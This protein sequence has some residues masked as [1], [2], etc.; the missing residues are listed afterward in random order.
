MVPAVVTRTR[1]GIGEHTVGERDAREGG[2]RLRVAGAE[3]GVITAA[4]AANWMPNCVTSVGAVA[5]TVMILPRHVV[6]LGLQAFRF[7]WN[8]QRCLDRRWLS[9]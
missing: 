7:R 5:G 1:G 9:R 8:K 4:Q 6:A 2:A 3:V